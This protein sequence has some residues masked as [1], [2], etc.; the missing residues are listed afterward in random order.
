VQAAKAPAGAVADPAPNNDGHHRRVM[1]IAIIC[2][3]L[4]LGVMLWVV[5]MIIAQQ[6]LERCLAA[7]RRDCLRIEVPSR[8]GGQEGSLWS[9]AAFTFAHAT[10]R[11]AVSWPVEISV[12]PAQA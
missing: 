9:K 1:L 6:K 7:G 10:S 2:V 4:L 11:T 5:Q 3:V 12:N 8:Y